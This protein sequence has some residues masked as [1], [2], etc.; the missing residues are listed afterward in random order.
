MFL[1]PAPPITVPDP[2]VTERTTYCTIQGARES[3]W[4]REM[5]AKGPIDSTRNY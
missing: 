5:N 3:D 1:V 4:V 2:V